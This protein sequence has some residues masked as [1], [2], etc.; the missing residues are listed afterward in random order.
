MPNVSKRP[1]EIAEPSLEQELSRLMREQIDS[2]QKQAF[3]GVDQQEFREQEQ[4]LKRI[5][6]ISAE[7][8]AQ[9][10]QHLISALAG[11]TEVNAK[12][13][14]EKPNMTLAGR[15]E[16]II[17]RPSEPKKAEIAVEGADPLYQEIRIENT[18]QDATGKEV[19]LKPG[20][21][22]D[23]KIEAEPENTRPK[24]PNP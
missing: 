5:R 19:E 13:V 2:L 1:D 9:S 14:K 21:Q 18:L 15:V 7:I 3:G 17:E 10:R 12:N 22:V 16:K 24:K 23:V 11:P 20:A 4:R 8:I 6:E